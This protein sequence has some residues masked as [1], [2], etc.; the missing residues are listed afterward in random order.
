[1]SKASKFIALYEMLEAIGLDM[2]KAD[3][4]GNLRKVGFTDEEITKIVAEAPAFIAGDE[5]WTAFL[6]KAGLKNLAMSS[7][8]RQTDKMKKL[9]YFMAKLKHEV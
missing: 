4:S 2:L 8:G 3:L 1:M 7:A 6:K 5:E 9:S